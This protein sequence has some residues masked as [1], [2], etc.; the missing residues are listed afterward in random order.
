VEA[1]RWSSLSPLLD[2][3]LELEGEARSRRLAEI[4]GEDPGLA[5]QLQKLMAL[6]D[7]NPDF[8]AEP[9]AAPD[10]FEP[11]PGQEIGPYRLVVPLGEGGMGQVW[12]AVRADGLYERRVALKLLRPGFGDAGLRVRF[13]RERQ[14]L[15]RLGHA[16]IARLLDAGMSLDGQPYLALDYVQGLPIT[17]YAR[18]NALDIAARLALFAQV[19]AAVSHAHANLV[20][21]RDLKPSNI[22][23]TPAGEVVLLDFGIAK[24]LDQ[25][26]GPAADITRTGARAF[27]LHYA[28]P[29]QLRGEPVTTMTDVYALGVV[30]YELLTDARPYEL[31]RASDAA[32]EEAILTAEPLR[33]SAAA[34]RAAR[35]SGQPVARRRARQIA[36][37]L[38]NILLKAL[39]KSPEERYPSVEALALDLRRFSEGQ[40]VLARPQS[41]W[42][43]TRKY[44]QRHALTAG[45]GVGVTGVLAVALVLVT[46]QARRATAEATRAL[47]ENSGED[48]DAALDARELLAAGEQRAD[49]ELAT[50]PQARAELLGL[51]ARLRAGLGDSAEALAVLDR[52]QALLAILGDEAPPGVRLESE[53]LRGRTLRE[54]GRAGDCAAS[55]E[56]SLPLARAAEDTDGLPAAEFLSQLGRCRRELGQLAIARG[57]FE[58]AMKRRIAAGRDV[59]R[60]ETQ[61]DL[62]LV[63]LDGGKPR[64]AVV[65]LR[66]ALDR[67][68]E[69]G[70]ERN[71]LGASIW[72]GLGEANARAG[73]ERESEAAYRQA[74]DIS[75]SRFG[76]NH[77]RT[78]ELQVD[79]AQ[80]LARAG[81][82]GEAARL[83]QL[84]LDQA[85]ARHGPDAAQLRPLWRLRGRI[86][87][88]RDAV[89][90][91][92]EAFAE[93]VRL[94]RATPGG[95]EPDGCLLAQARLAR[96][97]DTGGVRACLVAWPGVSLAQRAAAGA[98][99]AEV[100]LDR[101][102]AALARTWLPAGRGD[103]V[104]VLLQQARLAVVQTEPTAVALLASL[105]KRP[106]RGEAEPDRA[107]RWQAD[108]VRADWQCRQGD[109]AGG[110]GLR[111]Q[112]L[113]EAVRAQPERERLRRRLGVL[114]GACG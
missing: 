5:A 30:L 71:A 23:V 1:E 65:A 4:A 55:L 76:A 16:H 89:A 98:A 13:T 93:A 82:L 53:A 112:V 111:A 61:T 6:E 19:C 3:L 54:L 40:P 45:L 49:A 86:A 28:A 91:A 108:A 33:P 51:I 85:L 35:E 11:R 68:R 103:D 106:R 97:G 109:L 37:D 7:S 60:A 63:E 73:E 27:T 21:H 83:V 90:E 79:L 70:G 59:L 56:P 66:A 20:V 114:S 58:D 32:W 38:D 62:A 88:E 15:A 17:D 47:F 67:L 105:P 102:D 57:L 9:L 14:I 107:L 113:G 8:L 24:L 48:G 22:L 69:A 80:V 42:Y 78:A 44:L 10:A 96:D 34:M 39:S 99:L 46:W 36:G 43:R 101:G 64:E 52:Q 29:E 72:R 92:H 74:L 100:A 94:A 18:R 31:A 84:A 26:S 2:E 81:K 87:W 50:Q 104:E 95:A 110:R 77:P 12:L 25:P 75:L 41:L